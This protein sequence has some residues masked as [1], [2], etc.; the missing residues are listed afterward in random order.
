MESGPPDLFTLS[1]DGGDYLASLGRISPGIRKIGTHKSD[2]GL[3]SFAHP[4][5][6]F[7]ADYTAL[8]ATCL[9]YALSLTMPALSK[10][11]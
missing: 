11:F 10:L 3:G 2:G 4:V 6:F 1:E 5:C 7:R 8:G 9:I